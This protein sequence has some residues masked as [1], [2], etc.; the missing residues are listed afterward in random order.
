M[1]NATLKELAADLADRRFSSV[2]LTKFFLARIDGRIALLPLLWL[3]ED[4]TEGA[5]VEGVGE[6]V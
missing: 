1:L 4:D 2:E 5:T 3:I 6:R